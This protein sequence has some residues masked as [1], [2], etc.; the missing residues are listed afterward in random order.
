M[1]PDNIIVIAPEPMEEGQ[2]QIPPGILI[3][4]APLGPLAQPE[5]FEDIEEEEEREAENPAA[6]LP[7]LAPPMWQTVMQIISSAESSLIHRFD[8]LPEWRADR[9]RRAVRQKYAPHD[10]YIVDVQ[11]TFDIFTM[12][13]RDLVTLMERD[14]REFDTEDGPDP[15]YETDEDGDVD[16]TFISMERVGPPPNIMDINAREGR[17]GHRQMDNN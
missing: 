7:E 6:F 15:G 14:E 3:Q 4:G 13:L 17:G 10:R 5:Q 12:A 9:I 1:N 2:E 8:W 11:G 16:P